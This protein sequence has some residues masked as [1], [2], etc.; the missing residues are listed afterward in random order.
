MSDNA[1]NEVDDIGF[2]YVIE[3][4]CY[5]SSSKPG[6]KLYKIGLTK[7]VKQRLRDLNTTG[8]PKP[9]ILSRCIKF[10]KH[11]KVEKHLHNILDSD[12]EN[13]KREYFNTELTRINGII[14][15]YISTISN[16][17][18]MDV[19]KIDDL[20]IKL[21]DEEDD[22]E[23]EEDDMDIEEDIKLYNG[24]EHKIRYVKDTKEI[25][26]ITPDRGVDKMGREVTLCYTYGVEN[27][28]F[29]AKPIE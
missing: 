8:V 25:I 23:I 5:I 21:D 7:N 24:K 26:S 3:N 6:R 10:H 15:S 9:F 11:T 12:R 28:R 1:K 2:I 4:D 13:P 27:P 14:N 20:V 29:R 16:Y 18:E 19:K 17:E 22:Y